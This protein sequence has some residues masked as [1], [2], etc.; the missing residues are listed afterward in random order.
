MEEKNVPGELEW[1][2]SDSNPYG[3]SYGQWTVRWWNWFLSTPKPVNPILDQSGEFASI[4]QPSKDVW[5]LSG[6]MADENEYL[7]SRI[8]RI[9]SK[10]SVLFPIINCEAN[11]LEYP[12]LKSEQALIDKVT[13]DEN[14]IVEKVCF[15]DRKPI[16][17]QR[18]KSDPTIFELSICDDN[19]INLP[20]GGKTIAHGDGYWV[21]LKGMSLGE[22]LVSFSGSCENGRLRSGAYYDIIVQG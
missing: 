8:C 19:V 14:T 2:D 6:K 3:L 5:F 1:F 18:V 7:P 13:A 22:H 21:F 4:N 9:P 17:A 20:K 16:P 12:E 11:P 15:L 10:R